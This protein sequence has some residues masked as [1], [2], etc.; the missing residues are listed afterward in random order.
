MVRKIRPFVFVVFTLI[1][2]GSWPWLFSTAALTLNAWWSPGN[3]AV[4]RATVPYENSLGWLSILNMAGDI[5]TKNNAFFDP[6]GTNGRGCVTCHQP[7]DGMSISVES[8]KQRWGVTAGSDPLFAA[9]DGKN[10]PDL[11]DNYP[12]SHS[13]L[14]DRGLIRVFLPWPPKA[15][16][17]S[18][19][20]P[21]FTIEVVRDPTGCNTSPVYGLNSPT[22]SISVYRRPRPAANLKYVV[23]D[24][25]GVSRFI[26]KNGQPTERDPETGKLAQMNMMADAR[27]L[28][29]RSQ[30][31]SA[32]RGHLQLN[33]ALT[34]VQLDQIIGFESQIYAAQSF[35][36]EAGDLTE[37]GGP[38]ALGPAALAQGRTGVLGNNTTNFV[39]PMG[40]GWKRLP[41]TGDPDKDTKNAFRESVARGHDVFFY[42]TFW[43]RDAMHLNTVGLGN[44]VKRTC[45]TCHG[46]HMTGMDTANG[47]MDIGTTN[48]PWAKEA[49]I[50]P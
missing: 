8:I 35:H 16:D 10:C 31:R 28:S 4:L 48:L 33:G 14:L 22:P 36:N 49:T 37:R 11:P 20:K 26:A 50:S 23:A 43:I 42:R 41:R 5:V 40:E 27:E 47:W 19:V 12:Q 39:F 21:E 6:I 7:A 18:V 2:I 24:G 45:S 29:L 38:P 3:G 34:D 25:F 9:V 17:G 44:P 30:A 15:A 1:L 32:A 13:L 46:M